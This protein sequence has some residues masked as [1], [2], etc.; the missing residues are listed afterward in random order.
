MGEQLES[1]VVRIFNPADE[2]VGGD[3]LDSESH[4]INCAHAMKAPVAAK[5]ES[6]YQP[7]T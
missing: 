6:E 2:I 7:Y 1:A 3:F 4:V 5:D